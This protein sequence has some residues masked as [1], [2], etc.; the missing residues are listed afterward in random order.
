M[1]A[2]L[3]DWFV[4]DHLLLRGFGYYGTFIN[5]RVITVV[6]VTLLRDFRPYETIFIN[7]F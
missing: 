1:V 6:M 2:R 7:V 5:V 3:G 4:V